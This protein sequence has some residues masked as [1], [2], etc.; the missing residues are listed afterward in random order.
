MIFSI[1]SNSIPFTLLLEVSTNRPETIS[2]VAKDAT[3]R[4]GEG[5]ADTFYISRVADV[6]GKRLFELKFPQTPKLMSLAVFNTKKGNFPN[7]EDKSFRITKFE[8]KELKTCPLWQDKEMHSF[9]KFA[10]EFCEQAGN[11]SA[12]DYKPSIYRSNDGKFCIDYYNKIRNRKTGEY[13][14]TPARVGHNTGIIE[15]AKSDFAKYT[16]PMRIIILLHEFSHKFMNPKIGRDISD[17][18]SADIN[19]LNIYLSL[20][21]PFIEAQYAFL[22]VFRGANNEGNRK[23]YLI[24]NDFITKFAKGELTNVCNLNYAV[25]S[26]KS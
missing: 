24:L 11:L 4:K 15:I 18:V 16:V 14:S 22:K 26:V 8:A 20:G 13:V 5:Q 2:I 9:I 19:A 12:G 21:Y 10:Q 25:D 7:D 1:P 3:V 17:E 23:R 6:K